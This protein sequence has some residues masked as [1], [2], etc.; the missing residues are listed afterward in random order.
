MVVAGEETSSTSLQWLT[1]EL[2]KHPHIQ[3]K[4]R[5]E[6]KHALQNDKPSYESFEKLTYVNAVIMEN[7]R[8][9]SPVTAVVK[10]AKKDMTLGK[11][12]IPK[13]T[14]IPTN[15]FLANNSE[16]NWPGANEFNPDRFLDEE[17]RA[18]CQ[19]DFTFIPFSMGYRKCIGY[20]F[21]EIEIFCVIVRLLQHYRFEL[22]NKEDEGDIVY[23]VSAVTITPGN[24]KVRIVPL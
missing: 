14:F 17:L 24:L 23:P 16:D 7:L 2:A 8:Y 18:K 4:A 19:H 12:I 21:A 20:K 5:E 6:I 15:L 9:H 22:V 13:G 11:F 10:V 1:Y 3:E